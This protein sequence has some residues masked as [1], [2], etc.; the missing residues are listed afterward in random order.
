MCVS[1]L[2]FMPIQKVMLCLLCVLRLSSPSMCF[3][4]DTIYM[5]HYI[6]II[7]NIYIIYIYIL[8]LYGRSAGI[9]Q[10]G[11]LLAPKTSLNFVLYKDM[12]LCLEVSSVTNGQDLRY[13]V[14]RIQ[15]KRGERRR[16]V[17]EECVLGY[18]Y[19]Y[20]MAHMPSHCQM[21]T[22]GTCDFE[23]VGHHVMFLEV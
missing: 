7:Y 2:K 14:V 23:T 10:F 12:G 5:G 21:I 20:L 15:E 6:A 9:S 16:G 13:S 11:Y 17:R 4:L 19:C 1:Y 3:L 18:I 8:T 22:P